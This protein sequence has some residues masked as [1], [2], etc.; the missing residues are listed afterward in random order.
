VKILRVKLKNLNSLRG[1]HEVDFEAEPLAGTG[2]F[3]ITGPTGAG[4]STLLDAITLALYGKAA[5][6]GSTPSPEDMMSRHCGECWA[7]VEFRVPSGTYRAE[8][9]IHRARGSAAGNVQAAKRFVYDAHGQVLTQNVREA[10]VL[11]EKL[12]GLDYE[13]FLRSALLAQGQ[14]AQFLKARPDERAAL[15]ESLTGISIYSELGALAHAEAV[16]REEELKVKESA[17]QQIQL[18]EEDQRRRLNQD[19]SA[20]EEAFRKVKD[21]LEQANT[22]LNKATN[23]AAAL[24]REKQALEVDRVLETERNAAEAD[25]NRL[26]RHRLTIPFHTDFALVEAAEQAANTAGGFLK[27]EKEDHSAASQDARRCLLGFRR[28]IGE[29][30]GAAQ[31]QIQECEEKAGKAVTR[32]ANAEKWLIEHESDRNLPDKLTDIAS[33]L[34]SLKAARRGIA[35]EWTRL[36]N[37]ANKIDLEMAVRLPE[38]AEELTPEETKTILNRLDELAAV[39]RTG[40]EIASKNAESELELRTDHLAKAKLVARFEDHRAEL[41]NGEP[42]PL[43]GATDH[44]YAEGARPSFPFDV[45]EKRVTGAKNICQERAKELAAIRELENELTAAGEGLR[46]AV[47]EHRLIRKKLRRELAAFGIE[48]PLAGNDDQTRSDLQKRAVAH[49]TQ[50]NEVEQA[51]R[52]RTMA[53]TDQARFQIELAKLQEKQTILDSM[54]VSEL[55]LESG[56]AADRE[57]PLPGWSSVEAAD[58]DWNNRKTVLASKRAT[59]RGR[60]ADKVRLDKDVSVLVTTLGNK[61]AGSSFGGIDDLKAARLDLAD[62]DRI[63]KI[64]AKLKN[65]GD[66]IEAD[67]RAARCLI[68]QLRNQSTPEGDALAGLEIRKTELQSRHN[69]LISNLATWNNQIRQDN[70]HRQSVALKQKEL[71]SDHQRLTVWE[72]LRGLIGSHDGRTFRRY[73]QGISLDILVYY[74]NRHVA[75]LSD[76]Y[77]LRRCEGEELELEVADLHQAGVV[78]PM[79]S[80]SGGESFLVSLALALGLSDIAGRNVRIESLFIDEGFGSL[81]ADTLDVAISALETLRQDNKTVGVISHVDLLKERI[82]TQ[83]IVEKQSGGTSTLRIAA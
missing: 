69:E 36:C 43:C 21:E 54:R 58:E 13:R 9:R 67:L 19:I 46:G 1:S 23:L 11:I 70:T 47:R 64:E 51:E 49:Q 7:E 17:I 74:A 30:I 77:R 6:Y 2:L 4:K 56:D 34:A 48:I 37:T 10:D 32:K 27:Q 31:K 3:A 81:D 50:S 62:A 18:L 24:G 73:A 8:W 78:R 26:A 52:E 22:L 35:R 40:A 41:K 5:R 82:A 28:L 38:S 71:E 66:R 45:L 76:R 15:L 25:L 59:L 33:D 60:E 44:P 79:A 75:R 12:V 80:L 68:G 65:C 61:L 72:R 63:E 14:F 20:A 29:K 83:I 55:P 42:C 53:N 16:R 57:E 39:K